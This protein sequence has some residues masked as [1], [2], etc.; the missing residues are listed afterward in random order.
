MGLSLFHR[1]GNKGS[2]RLRNFPSYTRCWAEPEC[3][4]A[5][6]WP[7]SLMSD[8]LNSASCVRD[9]ILGKQEQRAWRQDRM[10]IGMFGEQPVI[11]FAW[12]I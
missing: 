7:H 6:V 12:N 5:S 9:D 10:G 8:T 3:T 1:Q 11:W 4:V 2:E